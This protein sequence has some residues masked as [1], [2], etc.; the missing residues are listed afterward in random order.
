MQEGGAPWDPAFDVPWHTVGGPAA[1]RVPR[2]GQNSGSV[3][4]W[5]AGGAVMVTGWL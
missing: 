2:S 1:V 5:S 4:S 3:V